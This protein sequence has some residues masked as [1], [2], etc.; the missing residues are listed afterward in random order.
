VQYCNSLLRLLSV[1]IPSLEIK[2]L[3][4]RCRKC[5]VFIYYQTAQGLAMDQYLACVRFCK[6]VGGGNTI[7]SSMDPEKEKKNLFSANPLLFPS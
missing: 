6:S 1:A 3:K 2:F 5:V 7:K 4:K